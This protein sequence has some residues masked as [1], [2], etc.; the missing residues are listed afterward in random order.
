MER[1]GG[2]QAASALELE[3]L[4]YRWGDAYEFGTDGRGYRVREDAG[5]AA[6]TLAATLREGA[7][8]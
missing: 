4:R 5:Q 6:A 8:R 2:D 7:I 1:A 3:D